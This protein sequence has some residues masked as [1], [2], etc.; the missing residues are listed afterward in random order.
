MT[1]LSRQKRGAKSM[2]LWTRWSRK[3]RSNAK[4]WNS[5]WEWASCATKNGVALKFLLGMSILR[6]EERGTLTLSQSTYAAKILALFGLFDCNGA[7]IPDSSDANDAWDDDYEPPTGQEEFRSMVGSLMYLHATKFITHRPA[8]VPKNARSAATASDWGQARSTVCQ[9]EDQKWFDL[10]WCWR[11]RVCYSWV[12]RQAKHN[13]VCVAR[14]RGDRRVEIELAANRRAFVVWERIRRGW[15]SNQWDVVSSRALVWSWIAAEDHDS[16]LRQS[17]RIRHGAIHS[18]QRA[19]ETH[20]SPLALHPP[21]RVWRCPAFGFCRDD[22]DAGRRPHES[23]NQRCIAKI[24]MWR[25]EFGQP[26]FIGNFSQWA[27]NSFYQK[28]PVPNRGVLED[29]VTGGYGDMQTETVVSVIIWNGQ[30]VESS[31]ARQEVE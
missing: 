26:N 23:F 28:L 27:C 6:D 3:W 10:R 24:L 17:S 8:F 20:T 22:G 18:N 29:S 19:Q 14:K 16:L 31:F 15:R 1:L 13:W 9:A 2:R 7:P 25:Y 12:L 5:Y 21:T 11:R 30:R 4:A